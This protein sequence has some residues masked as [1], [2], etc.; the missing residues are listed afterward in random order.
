MAKRRRKARRS[1]LGDSATVHA[2]K[3][4]VALELMED[5]TRQGEKYL[6]NGLCRTATEA[7]TGALEARGAAKEHRH[8]GGGSTGRDQRLTHASVALQRLRLNILET[9]IRND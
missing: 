5:L 6:N 9:C 8:S 2:R 7:L 1:Y 4:D 3:L